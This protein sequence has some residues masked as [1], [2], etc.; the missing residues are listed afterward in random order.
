MTS[1][2]TFQR[3]SL[4]FAVLAITTAVKAPAQEFYFEAVSSVQMSGFAMDSAIE[5]AAQQGASGSANS[6]RTKPKPSALPVSLNYSSAPSRTRANIA[7]FAAKSR[8]VDPKG[9]AAME[10][11]FAK[12]DVMAIVDAEMRKV[13][14]SKNNVADAYTAWWTN[15][16][17][18]TQGRNDDLPPSQLQAV[19]HQA[20]LALLATMAVAMFNDAQKREL[21]EAL[22]V[23]AML[24]SA[25]VDMA[26]NQPAL[27]PQLKAAVA[28][29]AKAT[30]VDL[31]AMTLTAEGFRKADPVQR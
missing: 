28:K 14:L 29:G 4:A 15:A 10:Q 25:A 21:A 3:L 6:D 11:L 19:K 27:M 1:A 18:A 31:A 13:G 16:W 2:K 8:K 26:K 30:G 22:L 5:Y 9:A 24:I 17:L 7:M 23:Q 20:E 12:Q